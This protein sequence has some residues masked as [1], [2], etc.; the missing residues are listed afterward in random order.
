LGGF[1]RSSQHPEHRGVDG[2]TTGL[3]RDGDRKAADAVTWPA[4]GGAA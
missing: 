1:N 4:A 2:T 3:G